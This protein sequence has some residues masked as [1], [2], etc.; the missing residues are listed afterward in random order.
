[1]LT[2]NIALS[3]DEGARTLSSHHPVT[4]DRERDPFQKNLKWNMYS[5]HAGGTPGFSYLN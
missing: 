4:P 1:V 2:G 3:C 5:S